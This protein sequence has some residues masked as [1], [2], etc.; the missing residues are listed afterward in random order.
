M[1][2][3]DHME[4]WNHLLGLFPDDIAQH[5][6][7]IARQLSGLVDLIRREEFLGNVEPEGISGLTTK[8][9]YERLLLTEWGLQDQY[10]DEF[11]RRAVSGEHLFLDLQRVEKKDD[12]QCFALFDCGPKQLGRPRLVQLA[13][14][15][16][17]ARRA[18]KLGVNFY[19]GILQDT[20]FTIYDEVSKESINAWLHHRVVNMVKENQ[21]SEWLSAFTETLFTDDEKVALEDLWLVTPKGI[22]QKDCEMKQDFIQLKIT[23]PLF[24][25]DQIKVSVESK[26]VQKTLALTLNDEAL[27]V[28]VIRDPFAEPSKKNTLINENHT[29]QWV[30]GVNGLRIACLNSIGKFA[31]Y[32]LNKYKMVKTLP[33]QFFS[34]EEN[35]EPL[36]AFISKKLCLFVGYDNDYL[37][38]DYFPNKKKKFKV[39]RPNYLNFT[40]GKL[41]KIVVA[42]ESGAAYLYILDDDGNVDRINILNHRD[43]ME[44]YCTN[45]LALGQTASCAWL[46]HKIDN[47]P[48]HLILEWYLGSSPVKKPLDADITL[49]N[50][51][52]KHQIFSH[53]SGLWHKNSTGP[54]A[55]EIA[56]GCW[57]LMSGKPPYNNVTTL[58]FD[59]D[60]EVVGVMYL[61]DEMPSD[62][63]LS[64]YKNR[65]ML[66]VIDKYHN[67]VLGVWGDGEHTFFELKTGFI[68]GELNPQYPLLHY[69]DASNDL[70]VIN[71]LTQKTVFQLEQGNVA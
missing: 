28:R 16:L 3:P 2:L 47:E 12:R 65:A 35:I 41:A 24:E 69:L 71:L 18:S 50:V 39:P 67:A 26:H 62:S 23:E 54:F 53:G 32:S 68:S 52:F 30:V 57:E 46:I 44:R 42:R 36:G 14:L 5:L 51:N 7:T 58:T 4:H 43:E 15:I 19:W 17:L 48:N 1:K 70:I 59:A 21:I 33:Q 63:E 66:I 27:N 49:E 60:H 20:D 37:Y 38:I 29:G 11:L 31:L 13:T 22:N 45:V 34:F 8:T 55:I 10:P 40:E 25:L 64:Q 56:E 6:N 9:N 61:K